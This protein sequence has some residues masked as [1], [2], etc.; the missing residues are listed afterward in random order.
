MICIVSWIPPYQ[1]NHIPM[2]YLMFLMAI[3]CCLCTSCSLAFIK[4]YG[5][6]IPKEL[7]EAQ[8]LGVADKYEVSPQDCYMLDTAYL[9]YLRSLDRVH[10]KQQIKNHCQPLQV[11]YY[12]PT[13][14][15]NSFQINC[16]VGG[17]P[18]L[19]WE[20]YE[21]FTTF[22]PKQ[23]APLDSILPLSTQLNFFIPLSTSTD[24]RPE[25]YDHIVVVFWNRWMGRQSKRLIALV[26]E[27]LKLADEQKVRVL[28]VNMDN[29]F[30]Y[31]GK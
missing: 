19:K 1:S 25:A 15:L 7:N 20:K 31:V 5:M 14:H 22:P 4:S 10:Y 17:F 29:Y 30:M 12:A 26:Q 11:L 18:N 27:N 3:I 23:Q 6:K 2:K 13:G 8:I 16:Y 9:T 21:T 28:Y 24:L